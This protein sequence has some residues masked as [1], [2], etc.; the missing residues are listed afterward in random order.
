MSAGVKVNVAEYE[1]KAAPVLVSVQNRFTLLAGS[2]VDPDPSWGWSPLVVEPV[3]V[4]AVVTFPNVRLIGAYDAPVP[5]SKASWRPEPV[6]SVLRRFPE[7]NPDVRFTTPPVEI[8]STLA[9]VVSTPC[10]RFSV[11]TARTLPS[12]MPPA[13]PERL[14]VSDWSSWAPVANRSVPS[15]PDPL[16]ITCDVALPR[17]A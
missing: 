17:T 14:T 16:T 2:T 10:V 11:G 3:T 1:L 8:A 15:A 9:P 13:T 12:A 5:T 7:T 6:A 4:P